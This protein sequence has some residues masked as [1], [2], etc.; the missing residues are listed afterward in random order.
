M[1]R[2]AICDDEPPI[3]SIVRADIQRVMG[4]LGKLCQITEYADGSDLVAACVNGA[5]F[6]IVILDIEM[7]GL[8]GR[9]TAQAL[10]ALIRDFV[11]V[12]L[13]NYEDYVREGYLVNAHRYL[14]KRLITTELP[15]AIQTAV[16]ILE[17]KPK[18]ITFSS[19]SHGL[20]QLYLKDILCVETVGRKLFVHTQ[21]AVFELKERMKFQDFAARFDGYGFYPCYRGILINLDSV[22]TLNNGRIVLIN[23]KSIPVSRH[24]FKEIMPLLVNRGVGKQ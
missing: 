16:A 13:T 14:L 21:A 15:E 6:E 4:S 12:F 3:R 19:I 23:G 9:Q 5:E 18:M 1:I 22:F 20:Q 7:P 11:L 10:R 2:L 24:Q 8:G 17:N